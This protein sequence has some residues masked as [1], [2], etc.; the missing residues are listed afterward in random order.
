[1]GGVEAAIVALA[2]GAGEDLAGP[3]SEPYREFLPIPPLPP[4]LT[5]ATSVMIPC[6]AT[7]CHSN[8]YAFKLNTRTMVKPPGAK[9][10]MKSHPPK[11]LFLSMFMSRYSLYMIVLANGSGEKGEIL[12]RN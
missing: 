4:Q 9:A 10:A 7:P 2:D 8:R 5:I 3:V 11:G 12:G 6:A 1:M